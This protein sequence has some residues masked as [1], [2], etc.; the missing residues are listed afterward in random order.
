M[1]FQEHTL[2]FLARIVVVLVVLLLCKAD[3]SHAQSVILPPPTTYGSA[4][5]WAN[6]YSR[7]QPTIDVKVT[8][9]YGDDWTPKPATF[10]WYF[11]V[12]MEEYVLGVVMGE[13]GWSTNGLTVP[14]WPYHAPDWT[15]ADE[16][17][18]AQSI[19][20]RTYGTFHARVEG[21]TGILN[22]DQYQVYR[23]HYRNFP[24]ATKT[25]YRNLISLYRGQYLAYSEPGATQRYKYNLIDSIYA[26][27]NSKPNTISWWAP[28]EYGYLPEVG[29]PYGAPGTSE[30]P[31]MPQLGA[32]G[33]ARAGTVSGIQVTTFWR[34]LSHFYPGTQLLNSQP[35]WLVSTYN[36]RNNTDCSGSQLN[37]TST[38]WINYDWNVGSLGILE[39]GRDPNSSI[40]SDNV[41]MRF[42]TTESFGSRLVYLLR[43]RGRWIQTAHRRCG[44]T[45]KMATPAAQHV[46]RQRPYHGWPTPH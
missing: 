19:A 22:T 34:I 18:K 23:P 24:E 11:D 20:A 5:P 1:A 25:R 17:V 15:W 35:M 32:H 31:G 21:G 39:N 46:L 2:R 45:L 13:L 40:P 12:D 44:G 30:N 6:G 8:N 38:N 33:M 7:P 36:G 26:S 29:N 37:L 27:D 16:A 14:T 28:N 3:V 10:P 9:E 41:C 42:T 4:N 43:G